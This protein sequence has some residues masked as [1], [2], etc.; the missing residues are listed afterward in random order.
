MD[1]Q[2]S[3]ESEKNP[4]IGSRDSN[5]GLEDDSDDSGSPPAGL[6]KG[7]GDS[8]SSHFP[9]G[10]VTP[11]LVNTLVFNSAK[12]QVVCIWKNPELH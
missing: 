8:P 5:E 9:N 10:N 2:E 4:S 12:K 1:S 11:I 3:F 7:E 6:N